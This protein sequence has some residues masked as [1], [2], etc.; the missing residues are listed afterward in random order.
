MENNISRNKQ[1]EKIMFSIYDALMS[2]K[3][4]DAFDV[5]QTMT[6]LFDAASFDDVPYFSKLVVIKALKNIT[7]II[8]EFQAHMP[9]WDFDRLNLV[10]QAILIMS[11]SSNKYTDEIEKPIAIS[12]AILLAKKYLDKDDYKFVNAILDNVLWSKTWPLFLYHH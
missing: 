10:E 3:N 9:K 8:K 4:K 11:Y 12:N 2:A 5:E 7:D 6:L 1:N